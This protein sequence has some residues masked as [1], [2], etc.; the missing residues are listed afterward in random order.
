MGNI[1]VFRISSNGCSVAS[2]KLSWSLF[3]DDTTGMLRQDD[4]RTNVSTEYEC[5]SATI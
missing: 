3:F 2:G 1:K 4:K 5:K